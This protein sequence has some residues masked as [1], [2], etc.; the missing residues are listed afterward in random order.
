M[1]W[2]V[3]CSM[4]TAL[5]HGDAVWVVRHQI[6]PACQFYW[7]KWANKGIQISNYIQNLKWHV[8][9]HPCPNFNGALVKTSLKFGHGW[10]ITSYCFVWMN[11]PITA[12]ASMMDCLIVSRKAPGHPLLYMHKASS[13]GEHAFLKIS[14]GLGNGFGMEHMSL[15]ISYRLGL[16]IEWLIL[17]VD[18]DEVDR[19]ADVIIG[20]MNHNRIA[21]VMTEWL[22]LWM[23]GWIQG[24]VLYVVACIDWLNYDLK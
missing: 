4:T 22:R 24:L 9:T 20:L 1:N 18:V 16:W 5:P 13:N 21:E 3:E 19:W 10:G 15:L 6:L 2:F 17:W 11:L 23:N 12:L 7:H 8:S 14:T